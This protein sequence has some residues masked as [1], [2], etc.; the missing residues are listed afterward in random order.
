MKLAD[1]VSQ[2]SAVT[3]RGGFPVHV[4]Q[5]GQIAQTGMPPGQPD[6]ILASAATGLV[7]FIQHQ[8]GDPE[9]ILGRAGIDAS[10]LEHPT[11]SLT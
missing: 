6:R 10:R 5:P 11:L 4:A 3:D 9:R 1:V 7:D 2:P 8:G